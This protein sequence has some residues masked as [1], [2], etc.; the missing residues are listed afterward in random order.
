MCY[1]LDIT[2]EKVSENQLQFAVERLERETGLHIVEWSVCADH[3][4]DPGRYIIFVE[5][6]KAVTRGQASLDSSFVD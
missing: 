5:T 3:E 1:M 4:T 2:G 6:E